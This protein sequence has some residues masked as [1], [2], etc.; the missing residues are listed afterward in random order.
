MTISLTRF[1]YTKDLGSPVAHSFLHSTIS[2][3]DDTFDSA[4]LTIGAIQY[5]IFDFDYW[6]LYSLAKLKSGSVASS[7]NNE[8]ALHEGEFAPGWRER[9]WCFITTSTGSKE[10]SSEVSS[11]ASWLCSS[12]GSHV[13]PGDRSHKL[14][15]WWY[16]I[17]D[18]LYS[19]FIGL[20][21]GMHV[22]RSSAWQFRFGFAELTAQPNIKGL[23]AQL[24]AFGRLVLF[25]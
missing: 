6:F 18:P 24:D 10:D 4:V 15:C 1:R 17:H 13:P 5:F 20:P 7:G 19:L 8:F 23:S 3:V 25:N 9:W 16:M 2:T 21:V 11:K 22:H 14:K 12:C